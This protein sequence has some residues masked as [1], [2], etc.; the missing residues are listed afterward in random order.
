MQIQLKQDRW[1]VPLTL[2]HLFARQ[3]FSRGLRSFYETGQ[4]ENPVVHFR[5][6]SDTLM[7]FTPQ[8]M[9][10]VGRLRKQDRQWVWARWLVLLM[11]VFSTVACVVMGWMLH[12][13][14]SEWERQGLFTSTTVFLTM[15]IWTKCCF[16][17]VFG[18]W[19]FFTAF[20]KWHGDVNRMLLLRLLDSQQ[21]EKAKEDFPSSLE[22]Q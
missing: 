18:L 22:S 8:E 2:I 15:L 17:L 5:W 13:L 3:Q 21:K 14:L 11:G 16:Y 1:P 6:H 12:L 20:V 7:Q 4:A 10:L 9:K 19:C